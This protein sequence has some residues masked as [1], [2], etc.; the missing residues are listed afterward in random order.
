MSHPKSDS[1]SQLSN[2]SADD[3]VRKRDKVHIPTTLLHH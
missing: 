2:S 3:E 1:K